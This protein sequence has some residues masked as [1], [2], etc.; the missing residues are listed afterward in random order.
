MPRVKIKWFSS[1]LCGLRMIGEDPETALLPSRFL[2][3]FSHRR[4]R[5]RSTRHLHRR[6]FPDSGP[7][8]VTRGEG[9]M[10]F[11]IKILKERLRNYDPSFLRPFA[12]TLKHLRWPASSAPASLRPPET[13]TIR[14][15]LIVQ[16]GKGGL[17]PLVKSLKTRLCILKAKPST[18]AAA[19]PGSSPSFLATQ[20]G[21][22]PIK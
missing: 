3:P 17:I 14:P 2:T 21:R 8:L 1:I 19:I 9:E 13:R 5:R 22:D 16:G 18:V 11:I 7:L 4:L 15:P 12:G 6:R 10:I 20:N